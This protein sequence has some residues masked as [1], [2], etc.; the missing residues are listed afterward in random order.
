LSS[1]VY[2]CLVLC[3]T[4]YYIIFILLRSNRDYTALPLG[5]IEINKD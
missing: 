5:I 4:V 2:M 3:Y 1:D